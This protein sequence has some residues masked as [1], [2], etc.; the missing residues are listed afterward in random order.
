MLEHFGQPR[1]H[2]RRHHENGALVLLLDFCGAVAQ[3]SEQAFSK[4]GFKHGHMSAAALF[5]DV[6][7]HALKVGFQ[8]NHRQDVFY[9][10]QI[11]HNHPAESRP[12]QTG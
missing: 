6:L 8:R 4:I 1:A 9:A 5:G 7:Q 12:Y 11:L 3:G 2:D 10:S